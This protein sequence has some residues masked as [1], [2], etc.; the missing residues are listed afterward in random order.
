MDKVRL[1]QVCVCVC[2]KRVH[3][4]M[5]SA[6]GLCVAAHCRVTMATSATTKSPLLNQNRVTDEQ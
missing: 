5:D 1:R 4:F 3:D 6:A 2:V